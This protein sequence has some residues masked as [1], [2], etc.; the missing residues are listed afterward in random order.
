MQG[1]LFLWPVIG[2]L[3]AQAKRV[4]IAQSATMLPSVVLLLFGGVVADRHN[5][6]NLLIGL[7]LMATLLSVGLVVLVIGE[8]P[9][10]CSC[11]LRMRLA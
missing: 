1:V 6:R 3:Q 9:F 8:R 2:V 7:P 5:R 11:S 10:L 4:G